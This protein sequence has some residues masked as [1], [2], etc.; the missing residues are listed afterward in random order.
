MGTKRGR[1]DASFVKETR[2][3][4]VDFYRDLVQG[5]TAWQAKAPQ[6]PEEPDEQPVEQPAPPPD[7]AC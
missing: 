2:R 5:L 4:A 1:G 6:L 7:T 3:Q